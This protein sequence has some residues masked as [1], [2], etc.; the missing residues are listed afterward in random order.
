MDKKDISY[1]NYYISYGYF[2]Q[3]Q[4]FSNFVTGD[5]PGECKSI[6][7]DSLQAYSFRP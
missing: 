2:T 6:G 3:T 7:G 4:L 5:L 1:N